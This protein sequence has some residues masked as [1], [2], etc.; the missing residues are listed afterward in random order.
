MKKMKD[1]FERFAYIKRLDSKSKT[2]SQFENYSKIYRS[3]INLDRYY[4]KSE[5]IYEQ[6]EKLIKVCLTLKIKKD[7]ENFFYIIKD[8]KNDKIETTDLEKLIHLKNK[9]TIKDENKNKN[10]TETNDK[11]KIISS[12]DE[13]ETNANLL[14]NENDKIKKKRQQLLNF[15]NVI[16]NLE[17]IM[18]YMRD[19]R[20]KGSSL[21]IE[22]NIQIKDM[23]KISYD[24]NDKLDNFN[25]IKNFLLNAKNNYNSLLEEKYQ[26][27]FNLRFLYGKQFKSFMNHLEGNEPNIDSF[28]R[29]ILN[30]TDNNVKIEEGDMSVERK[31][32]DFIN[33][34]KIYDE[35][36]LD[37]ISE[38][39]TSLF[40]NNHISLDDHFEQ[41]KIW[42]KDNR[43]IYLY[44]HNC[45]NSS[46]EQFIIN[47]F[48]DKIR[49]LPIAQ[50]ILIANKETSDEEIQAFFYRS[51]L[52]SYNTLFVVE[53]TESFSEY[54]Q[55]VMN[56]QIDQVLTYKI[57]ECTKGNNKNF[58]KRETENYLDSCIVFI[59]DKKNKNNTS[60]LKEIKKLNVQTVEISKNFTNIDINMLGNIHV[61]TSDSLS[62][63]FV[64]FVSIVPVNNFENPPFVKYRVLLREQI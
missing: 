36:S 32:E 40:L 16:L 56:N 11:D 6:V 5:N 41:M 64:A 18:E 7:S 35:D 10:E 28:L 59:Y 29:Y 37:N 55:T 34:Y 20:T 14:E 62:R 50:N 45:E 46:M 38:Y 61:I 17:I 54:Q 15:K 9:I 53:I 51:I 4:D 25:D 58:E 22:I 47:L 44:E 63:A 48:W 24:L 39:I 3:V 52:C 12:N 27:K 33:H 1:N 13:S 42:S 30:I 60:F 21:P 31:V 19:L 43:G 2:I 49:Q 23:N 57:E 26:H 8:D